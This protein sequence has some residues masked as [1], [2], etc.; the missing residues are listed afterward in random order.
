M[1]WKAIEAKLFLGWHFAR[2]L[3]GKLLGRSRTNAADFLN[4][5][6]EDHAFSL[7]QQERD[8]IPSFETC[9][10]CRQ[11]DVICPPFQDNLKSLPPSYVVMGLSRQMA[12]FPTSQGRLD[13]LNC[14]DC[15]VCLPECPQNVPV[16]KLV[17]F[18]KAHS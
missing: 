11:C 2:H 16:D 13:H 12:A 3:F 18:V 17:A 9:Y 1:S 10:Q 4:N 6:A 7:S 14:D 5:Y 8:A 15:G